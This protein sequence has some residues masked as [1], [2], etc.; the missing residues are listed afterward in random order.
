MDND[1]FSLTR[2][3]VCSKEKE[4]N[5]MF[6]TEPAKKELILA[7]KELEGIKRKLLNLVR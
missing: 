4:S 3:Q 2:K 7:L 6:L 5:V 1:K